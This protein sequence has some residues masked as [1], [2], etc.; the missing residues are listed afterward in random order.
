MSFANQITGPRICCYASKI[1]INDSGTPNFTSAISHMQTLAPTQVLTPIP[2]F[3]L[4][5]LARYIDENLQKATK[6]A[7]KLF[8]KGQKYNQI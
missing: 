1:L 3:A 2:T 4:S 8:I 5:P 6:L 7:I